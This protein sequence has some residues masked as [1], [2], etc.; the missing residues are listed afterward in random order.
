MLPHEENYLKSLQA[1]NISPSSLKTKR[2]TFAMFAEFLGQGR[3]K[4]DP[5]EWNAAVFTGFHEYL[6]SYTYRRAD[7]RKSG[8]IRDKEKRTYITYRLSEEII[9]GHMINMKL[10]IKY[11][12]G[13]KLLYH[14]PFDKI[15]I[16]YPKKKMPAIDVTEEQINELVQAIPVNTWLGFRDRTIIEMIYGTGIRLTE[17]SMLDASDIDDREYVLHIRQ[18]KGKKDR[19]VPIGTVAMQF[20]KEYLG[21]VRKYLLSM[22]DKHQE[23]LFVN[24]RGKRF[25]AGGIGRMIRDYARSKGL[26]R[27]TTHKLRHAFSLHMMRKGC[28]IR[29]IQEILGHENLKT[30]TVYTEVFDYD[31]K[32]KILQYHPAENMFDIKSDVKR[33][34]KFAIKGKSG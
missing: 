14:N 11:L 13:R 9:A 25:G 5:A 18:G 16:R 28:D 1:Q 15:F 19:L 27:I 2:R 22:D 17:T 23:A 6:C 34:K 26:Y 31:L 24:S 4:K 3:I 10:F 30:T 32:G 8:Y 12:L 20:V 29:Y 21:A 7:N 33:I